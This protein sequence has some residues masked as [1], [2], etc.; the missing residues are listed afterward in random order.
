MFEIGLILVT[1]TT[2]SGK[3]T[4][5]AAMVEEINRR[6]PHHIVTIEDPIE[7]SFKDRKSVI[8]Q[9]EVGVDTQTFSAGLRAALRQ[10]PD[11]VA[12]LLESGPTT[13]VPT[14]IIAYGGDR[15]GEEFKGNLFFTTFGG[16]DIHRVVLGP[17]GLEVIS[18]EIIIDFDLHNPLIGII[19]K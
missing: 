17:G 3:S 5:M 19:I 13:F 6:Y 1:G 9:R 18:D 14:E 8:N 16:G 15:Y 2:G 10:D 12:P 11:V 7:F 4:T